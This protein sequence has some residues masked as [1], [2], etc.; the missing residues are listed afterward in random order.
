MQALVFR[1]T[2]HQPEEALRLLQEEIVPTLSQ[3]PGFVTGYWVGSENRGT[4]MA[5]FESEQAAQ[6]ALGQA[7]PPP[8]DVVTLESAEVGEVVAH[9]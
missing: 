4:G 2:S 3:A 5:V 1:V 9:A 6:G 7:E 8:A